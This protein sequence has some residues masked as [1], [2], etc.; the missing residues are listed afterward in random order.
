MNI[1]RARLLGCV[2][3]LMAMLTACSSSSNVAAPEALKGEWICKAD[4]R[5]VIVTFQTRGRALLG[6]TG[7]MVAVKYTFNE[8]DRTVKLVGRSVELEGVLQEDGQLSL[9]ITS[10]RERLFGDTTAPRLFTRKPAD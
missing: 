4:D 8:Q 9:R 6:K 5:D 1:V 2:L 10:G 7:A 3:P